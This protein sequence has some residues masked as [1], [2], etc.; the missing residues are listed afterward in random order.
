MHVVTV[1]AVVQ[2]GAA[3]ATVGTETIVTVSSD[4]TAAR[5]INRLNLK[6]LMSYLV[7]LSLA[8]LDV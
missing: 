8:L 1:P 6:F 3:C 5:V 7:I 2:T 4:E